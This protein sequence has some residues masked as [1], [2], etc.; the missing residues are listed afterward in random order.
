MASQNGHR[1]CASS[2]HST[3]C[4]LLRSEDADS[5]LTIFPVD[6]ELNKAY[7]GLGVAACAT[8]LSEP[9]RKES[10]VCET[11]NNAESRPLAKV[12][13]LWKGRTDTSKFIA[14]QLEK[15]GTRTK[16]EIDKRATEYKNK[17]LGSYVLPEQ[18]CKVV[19]QHIWRVS[20][21]KNKPDK[22]SAKMMQAA[23]VNVQE[24]TLKQSQE[25]TAIVEKGGEGGDSWCQ[26]NWHSFENTMLEY[27]KLNAE[28]KRKMS[29][30]KEL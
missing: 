4:K 25:V 14:D 28:A 11:F 7:Q 15:K 13:E 5:Q 29:H 2:H 1:W 17:L 26:D 3:S 20:K 19:H 9:I 21:G 8:L 10:V 24:A 23:G 12:R 18:V 22:D 6:P 27:A 30:S 16:D